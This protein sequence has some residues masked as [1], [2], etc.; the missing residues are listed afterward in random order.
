M[1]NRTRA[2]VLLA[3]TCIAGLGGQAEAQLHWPDYPAKTAT[4]RVRLVA[5]AYALPR[6]TYGSSYEVFVAEKE[7]GD[8]EWSL[9]K[10]VFSFLSFQPRLSE[11]GLDYSVVHEIRQREFRIATKPSRT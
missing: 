11:S 10:L 7:I 8:G 9:I 5:V 2:L 3:A 4:M 6:S 1:L